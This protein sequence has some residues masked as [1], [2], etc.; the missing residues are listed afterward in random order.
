MLLVRVHQLCGNILLIVY[1]DIKFGLQLAPGIQASNFVLSF[2]AN[3][4]HFPLP[5]MQLRLGFL[6]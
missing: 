1:T 2:R 6:N 4:W 3:L 5:D